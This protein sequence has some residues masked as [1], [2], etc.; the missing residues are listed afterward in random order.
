M[1]ARLQLFGLLAA[2]PPAGAATA[3]ESEII[4]EAP[5]LQQEIERI[6]AADN[7]DPANLTAREV[8]DALERIPRGYAPDDFWAS[9]QRH[10]RAWRRYAEAEA[11]PR[12]TF[13]EY[14]R[15]ESAINATYE[16][17]ER[18]ALRYGARP[19]AGQNRWRPPDQ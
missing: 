9:Y 6:L 17:A 10:V 4:V 1:R 16:D 18:I 8:A 14:Q 15:V 3:Q 19:P 11:N 2:L 12:L 7:I 13:A 5:T